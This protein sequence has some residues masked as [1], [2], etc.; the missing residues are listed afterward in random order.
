MTLTPIVGI[1]PRDFRRIAPHDQMRDQ[2]TAGAVNAH[3]REQR[4]LRDRRVR[5]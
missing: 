3:L 4:A 1:G 5:A 2:E